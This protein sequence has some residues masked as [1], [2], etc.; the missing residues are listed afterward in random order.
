MSSEEKFKIMR[1]SPYDIEIGNT[2]DYFRFKKG[3]IQIYKD[4]Y[5]MDLLPKTG[6]E[7]YTIIFNKRGYI[8]D[9]YAK[10][11]FIS[12]DGE[13]SFK[14]DVSDMIFE[15]NSI[16]GR[17]NFKDVLY[18]LVEKL[19]ESIIER[20]ILKL[21]ESNLDRVIDIALKDGNLE[22]FNKAVTMKFS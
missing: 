10:V 16:M 4:E 12:Q 7:T 22:L 15:E 20:E 9:P 14:T 6:E 11:K 21:E 18:S 17:T 2:Y 8:C 19:P 5:I 1:V 13:S 3:D